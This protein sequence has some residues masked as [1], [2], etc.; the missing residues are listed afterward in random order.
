MAEQFKFL[1]DPVPHGQNGTGNWVKFADVMTDR[2]IIVFAVAGPGTAYIRVKG[3]GANP[4]AG[5]PL[6][7]ANGWQRITRIDFPDFVGREWWF[8]AP[9]GTNIRG[10]SVGGVPTE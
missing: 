8:I 9:V 7:S 10:F 6:T 5:I 2:D 3:A 4:E 1:R